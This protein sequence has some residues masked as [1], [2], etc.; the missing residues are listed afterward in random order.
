MRELLGDGEHPEDCL[1]CVAGQ[2]MRHNYEPPTKGGDGTVMNAVNQRIWEIQE[3][4]GWTNE[5]LGSLAMNFIT[6]HP[7]LEA[8]FLAY[9]RAVAG[10]ENRPTGTERRETGARG[11][12]SCVLASRRRRVGRS[13]VG[14][15]QRRGESGG[16][17]HLRSLPSG[18]HLVSGD[19]VVCGRQ[20]D[21]PGR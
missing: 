6:D 13:G 18:D 12:G 8:D 7:A 11:R 14:R 10:E 1:F 19:L 4:Q 21:V 15:E 5:T 2:P 20:H 9:L 3:R 16:A 17:Q